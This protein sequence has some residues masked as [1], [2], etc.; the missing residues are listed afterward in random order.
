MQTDLTLG[1]SARLFSVSGLAVTGDG[2]VYIADEGSLRLLRLGPFS[3]V[4]PTVAPLDSSGDRQIKIIS[5]NRL[6]MYNFNRHGQ[7]VSTRSTASGRTLFTFHYSQESASPLG[8]LT[9]VVDASG[10]RLTFL[11]DPTGALHSIESS[12]GFK[13]QT[14]INKAGLLEA[15]GRG[16][17]GGGVNG[18]LLLDYYPTTGLL[19]SKVD[20]TAGGATSFYLY[21]GEGRVV[22]AVSPTG[23]VTSIA[24]SSHLSEHQP[25]QQTVT[26]VSASTSSPFAS[27]S[28][29]Q[30]SS[31]F[32]V[33]V[34]PSTSATTVR[35]VQSSEQITAVELT[36]L[37]DGSLLVN[38][39]G[40]GSSSSP[41]HLQAAF[42]GKP[43][44]LSRAMLP[45]QAQ[46]FPLIAHARVEGDGGEQLLDLSL[47]YGL[48][49][50]SN[51]IGAVEKY[52]VVSG[53]DNSSSNGQSPV[54]ALK[55]E[56]DWK[57]NREIYYNGSQRPILYM[58]FDEGG[59]PI[60]WVPNLQPRAGSGSG[61]SGNSQQS[62]GHWPAHSISYD[63]SGQLAGWQDGTRT[64]SYSRDRIGRLVEVR[65]GQGDGHFVRYSY[66]DEGTA[67]GGNSGS[68]QQHQQL[69]SSVTL[70]SGHKY[71]FDLDAS[72]AVGRLKGI[73][74]PKGTRHDFSLKILL[75]SYR[76][77]YCPPVV[78][79]KLAAHST[80]NCYLTYFGEDR[81]KP[82]MSVLPYDH[83][84]VVYR[85]GQR[86]SVLLPKE[87]AKEVGRST[88]AEETS[89]FPLA[90]DQVLF[91]GGGAT[92]RWYDRKAGVD[93]R[94]VW[95]SGSSS[96]SLADKNGIQ[97]FSLLYKYA[98]NSGQLK[99]LSV[100]FGGVGSQ[101]SSALSTLTYSYRYDG[102][103]RLR[104]IQA[105]LGGV[106]SGSSAAI[107]LPSLEFTYNSESKV[108]GNPQI[109][110]MAAFRYFERS[111]NESLLGDGV[112]LYVKRFEPQS[113]VTTGKRTPPTIRHASL[114]IAD[115]EVF[116]VDYTYD[117]SSS[118]AGGHHL[119][120]RPLLT[121]TRTYMRH[122][123]QL[124]ANGGGSG[125]NNGNN[126]MRLQNFTYDSE[127]QLLEV[128]GREHWR[129]VYDFNGN[130]VTFLYLGN[131]IDIDYDS[132]DRVRNFGK[133]TEH[134]GSSSSSSSST[135]SS[136]TSSSGSSPYIT[137]LRG[138]VVQRGD[139]QLRYNSLGQLLS[140]T[141]QQP[142][143]RHQIDYTYD[144]R[145]RLVVRRDQAGNVTQFFYGDPA[146]PHLV[147][148]A[149]SAGGQ[150]ISLLYDDVDDSLLS[151]RLNGGG[152]ASSE[153]NSVYY[154]VCDQSRSP[155][156]VF[157]A[158]GSVVKEL[159]RSP[160]GHVLFDSNPAFYLP[161][162]FQG[163]IADPLTNLVHFP[164]AA[165][166]VYDTLT[167]RWMTPVLDPK[168]FLLQRNLVERPRLLHQYQFNGND[169]IS[170]G[171]EDLLVGEITGATED[172]IL[173]TGA[174]FAER[175]RA[176][177]S[178][179][180][181]EAD[182]SLGPLKLLSQLQ[183]L[184]PAD[185]VQ[186]KSGHEHSSPLVR[187]QHF[188]SLAFIIDELRQ[189][190]SF[191]TGYF[192]KVG[193]CFLL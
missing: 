177:T 138:F 49:M 129:F 25:Q 65:G 176:S 184:L 159:H 147:T 31:T 166:R 26:V 137:D 7:H 45:M 78:E 118:S 60:Q 87:F 29:Q 84:K 72:S 9:D 56:Y 124:I 46:M 47:D 70:R 142:P 44:K 165:G 93:L 66:G 160:Y 81:R 37:S 181:A 4:P 146:R 144:Y 83:G 180:I 149:L 152:P 53:G 170:G 14:A 186:G 105:K 103:S 114:T 18:S 157:D 32:Q 148:H 104:A 85:Y 1:I 106:G 62:I 182:P 185:L 34:S 11:R 162:D 161:V 133:G 19:R 21:N 171:G 173:S 120:Q 77:A 67:E 94:G 190:A 89:S 68:A 12:T 174:Q 127:G 150:V 54:L 52:V 151:V 10:A 2:S 76:F 178:S 88:S 40:S 43:S 167:G 130:L 50:K 110:T 3:P 74:T 107:N 5:P 117:S 168:A 16:G 82:V 57:A 143:N 92:E 193:F 183:E 63:K 189:F 96:S 30:S 39:S 187:S 99:H 91:G 8:R 116:R 131:R 188:T 75:G 191:K 123:H 192:S 6:E 59:R 13:A 90:V 35:L 153:P 86:S 156:L 17:G 119:L 61:G 73:I 102:Q 155:L 115:K 122:H 51:I 71:H 121:Q 28:D 38:G 79:S 100:Q 158:R 126:K 136:S 125:V 42:A 27:T 141:R 111:A 128:Q 172:S 101:L 55:M 108:G 145:G 98:R 132:A 36:V 113:S 95:R 140:S 164:A 109:E 97:D 64:V 169:P 33:S 69:P 24:Q 154:V 23:A 134:G 22:G 163:G 15:I 112:A 179:L 139:E 20:T 58:Q 175:L 48:K 135:S 80:A 41:R